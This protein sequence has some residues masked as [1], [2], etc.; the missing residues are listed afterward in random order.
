[1]EITEEK[2]IAELKEKK[3]IKF[4][5]YHQSTRISFIIGIISAALIIFFGFT[6]DTVIWGTGLFRYILLY[7]LLSLSLAAALSGAIFGGISFRKEKNVFN[8]IG[9]IFNLLA[10]FGMSW[11]LY[12]LTTMFDIWKWQH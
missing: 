9:F 12:I 10:M 7:I 8:V 4:R 11:F 1:M 2:E 3:I 5:E 6:I